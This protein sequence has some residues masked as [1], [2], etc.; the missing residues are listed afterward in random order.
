LRRASWFYS[1]TQPFPNRMSPRHAATVYQFVN[2]PS[3]RDNLGHS[4]STGG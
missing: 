3:G 1:Y 2:V 4:P